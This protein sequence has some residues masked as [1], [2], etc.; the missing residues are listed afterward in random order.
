MTQLRKNYL[1][2]QSKAFQIM[3]YLGMIKFWIEECSNGNYPWICR[4]LRLWHPFVIILFPFLLI[5]Q[6][7]KSIGETFKL[8]LKEGEI[9]KYH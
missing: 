7:I 8:F 9:I 1:K 2:K 4:K 3:V 5:V 6:I